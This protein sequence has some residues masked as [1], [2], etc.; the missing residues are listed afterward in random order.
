MVERQVCSS[1]L[2]FDQ[3][4]ISLKMSRQLPIAWIH[5]AL[6]RHNIENSKQLFPEKE[7]RGHN[8]NFYIHVSVSDLYVPTIGL[9]ILLQ[10]NMWTNPGNVYKSLTDT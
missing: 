10:E 3:L 7:L 6:Q 5:T 8:P 4:F 2:K 9:P 1:F